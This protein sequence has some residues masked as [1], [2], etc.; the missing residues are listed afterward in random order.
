MYAEPTNSVLGR[1][2]RAGIG[3]GGNLKARR[4]GKLEICLL[5]SLSGR[6]RLFP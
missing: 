1:F 6:G 3:F 4:G 5:G 2:T